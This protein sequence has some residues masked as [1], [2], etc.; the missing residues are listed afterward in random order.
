MPRYR[1]E[2]TKAEAYR[3]EIE[4]LKK[5]A[6]GALGSTALGLYD[7]LSDPGVSQRDALALTEEARE[8]LIALRTLGIDQKR[9][10]EMIIRGHTDSKGNIK[11]ESL[12]PTTELV[13]PARK[14]LPAGRP[15]STRKAAASTAESEEAVSLGRMV[16]EYYGSM[17]KL[18]PVM[19][20]VRG[21]ISGNDE[22]SGLFRP[23]KGTLK[24]VEGKT[25]KARRV[26]ERLVAEYRR[27][28]EEPEEP[29]DSGFVRFSRVIRTH[30]AVRRI[31]RREQGKGGE[32]IK[33]RVYQ[34]LES[35]DDFV[36][37]Y[38][39]RAKGGCGYRVSRNRI[40][41]VVDEIDKALNRLGYHAEKPAAAVRKR[42]ESEDDTPLSIVISR[43]PLV[44][45]LRQKD[46]GHK[47]GEG[48]SSRVRYAIL[49]DDSFASQYLQRS[50]TGGYRVPKKEEGEVH[51]K[52]NEIL[53]ASSQEAVVSRPAQPPEQ[54]FPTVAKE[55]ERVTLFSEAEIGKNTGLTPDVI[56]KFRDM[57]GEPVTGP[58]GIKRYPRDNVEKLQAAV[59]QSN[60]EPSPQPTKPTA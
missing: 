50:K 32:G 47:R 57:L 17:W 25:A 31:E 35:D 8:A 27:K 20:Y 28:L 48:L 34:K 21:A 58:N 41:A 38:L 33:G 54:Q 19:R 10:V 36:A 6:A 55:P 40:P 53:Q 51:R 24:P 37:R 30:P 56:D 59:I 11:P 5:L 3:H 46:R 7:I 1:H 22:H 60:M 16:K 15:F 18:G 42:T 12:Y 29:G 13:A 23:Y 52:I 43:N 26:V 39:Q 9:L 2:P 45:R 49:S 44:S 4:R 14:Q